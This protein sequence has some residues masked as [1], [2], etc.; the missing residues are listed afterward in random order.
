MHGH[1]LPVRAIS[2]AGGIVALTVLQ[3][4]QGRG[5]TTM[6][7]IRRPRARIRGDYF[8]K[9]DESSCRRCG[10]AQLQEVAQ[11]L[12]DKLRVDNAE[13]LNRVVEPAQ[14]RD[15]P[16]DSAALV[17]VAWAEG[18]VTERER[19]VIFQIAASRGTRPA[20]RAHAAAWLATRLSDAPS[21]PHRGDE[22]R[23]RGVSARGARGAHQGDRRAASAWR[24]PA[25]GWRSCSA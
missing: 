1:P 3:R 20:R 2:C 10:R 25:V 12:A 5:A 14:S 22:G 18:R 8:R 17:Q 24:P 7:D 19:E 15:R 16:G 23:R 21:R 13:P 4:P 6:S 11:A 9:Q